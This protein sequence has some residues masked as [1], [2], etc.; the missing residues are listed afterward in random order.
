MTPFT[1][2]RYSRH[3][4]PSKYLVLSVVHLH[5]TQRT[6]HRHIMTSPPPT[7]PRLLPSG[8][9]EW[10]FHEVYTPTE[11]IEEYRPGNFHPIHFGDLLDDGRYRVIR[12]LGYGSYSTVWLARDD[13]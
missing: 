1:F 11:W 8:D 3:Y 7:P 10:R 4:W 5:R 9:S 12:K 2:V 6:Q 13:K